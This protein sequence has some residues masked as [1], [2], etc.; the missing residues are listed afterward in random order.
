MLAFE[1]MTELD[2]KVAA[3]KDESV[4]ERVTAALMAAKGA[5][6][7]VEMIYGVMDEVYGLDNLVPVKAVKA[8]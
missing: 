2:G 8:A 6:F 5:G 4:R 1:L 3:R 7:T